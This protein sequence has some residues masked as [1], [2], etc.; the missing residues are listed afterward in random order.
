MRR[1]VGGQFPTCGTSRVKVAK[2]QRDI[3]KGEGRHCEW[4]WSRGKVW[5]GSGMD[6]GPRRHL[7]QRSE[8]HGESTVGSFSRFGSKAASKGDHLDQE[9]T[10]N[11]HLAISTPY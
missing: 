2:R 4:E 3:G 10:G 7:S 8:K 1:V 5:R 11:T 9:Q 6:L